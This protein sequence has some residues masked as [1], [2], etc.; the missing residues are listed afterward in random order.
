V[1]ADGAV[2]LGELDLFDDI[3]LLVFS[4]A[5]LPAQPESHTPI[6]RHKIRIGIT[7]FNFFIL[8]PPY[9]IKLINR[10]VPLF[11]TKS[12]SRSEMRGI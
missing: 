5:P 10:P 2:K 8:I 1:F 9:L 3:P 7:F 6:A 11:K 12:R 4:G